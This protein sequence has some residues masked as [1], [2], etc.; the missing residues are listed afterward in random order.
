LARI[1]TDRAR[2]L[3]CTGN[4]RLSKTNP[5]MI[6]RR[7]KAYV[8]LAD[9]VEVLGARVTIQSV[10]A[11]LARVLIDGH[12]MARSILPNPAACLSASAR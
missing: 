9:V 11:G 6:R 4:S 8:T 12:V 10:F 3:N 7:P 5:G 1:I 2:H